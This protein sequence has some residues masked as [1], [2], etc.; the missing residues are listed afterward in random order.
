MSK[1]KQWALVLGIMLSTTALASGGGGEAGG[2]NFLKLEPV[3]V[4]VKVGNGSGYLNFVP[5]L[6][7]ADPLDAEFVKAHTPILR[8]MLIKTLL[9]QDGT[10]L[11]STEF[12]GSFSHKA[13]EILNKV[14]DGEYVKDVFFD[15][16]VIQ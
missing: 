12:M 13:A 10:T 5:Q 9:G 15:R 4:N 8:H 7:L 6:K 16:W 2:G 3:I 14:L 1:L 11:Q